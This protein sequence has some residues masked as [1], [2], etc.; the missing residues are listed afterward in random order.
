MDGN[1]FQ[2]RI[3]DVIAWVFAPFGALFL[4]FLQVGLGFLGIDD[5][6]V[7]PTL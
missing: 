5:I 6:I 3:E 4:A 1:Q 2:F 7:D